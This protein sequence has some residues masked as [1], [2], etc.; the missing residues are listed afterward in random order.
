[1]TDQ[2]H[3]MNVSYI[4]KED[5]LLLKISTKQGDE[6][7][8]WLTRRFTDLLVNVLK[9]EVD[10]CGGM[11]SIAASDETKRMFKE[12]AF[13]KGYENDSSTYPLGE[14]GILAFRINTGRDQNDNL[15]L[16]LSPEKGQGISLNLN[17]SL[18]YMFNNL[19]SQGVEQAGWNLADNEQV[20]MNIH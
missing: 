20:S 1:M 18:L 12:G 3:Q 8:L 4:P 6:Y 9:K 17:K 14:N 11:A 13:E 10:M 2:L 16:D 5:R 7:R 15:Q 19:I